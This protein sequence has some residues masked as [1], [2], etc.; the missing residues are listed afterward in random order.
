MQINTFINGGYVIHRLNSVHS[1]CRISAWFDADGS[2]IDAERITRNNK[3]L[4]VKHGSSL[5]VEIQHKGRL[6]KPNH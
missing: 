3:S 5:W 4:P 2:L 6:Y 1:E